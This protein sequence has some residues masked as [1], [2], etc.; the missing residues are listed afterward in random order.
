MSADGTEIE[1]GEAAARQ[2]LK[3]MHARMERLEREAAVEVEAAWQTQWR[4]PDVFALKVQT[5]LTM[6]P[7]YRVLQDKVRASEATLDPKPETT[8]GGGMS[9]SDW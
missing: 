8:S 6:N 7:E 9:L 5:R 2:E 3:V 1:G 4:N